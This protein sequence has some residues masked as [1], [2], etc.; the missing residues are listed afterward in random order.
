MHR[1]SDPRVAGSA[2]KNLQMFRELCGEKA[3]RNVV[4]VTNMWGGVDP[5]T[6]DQREQDLSENFL[7]HM[8]DQG[9]TMMR[10]DGSMQSAHNIILEVLRHRPRLLRIQRE[11]VREH[12]ELTET[13]ACYELDNQLREER[14]RFEQDL[15]GI[16][17]DIDRA[18]QDNDEG[19]QMELEQH[20]QRVEVKL[21]AM[22][23]ERDHLKR[24]YSLEVKRAK[25]A[26]LS[27]LEQ[28][29]RLQDNA[30]QLAERSNLPSEPAHVDN[31]DPPLPVPH[32]PRGGS[33]RHKE[34]PPSH[35]RPEGHQQQ[36][37]GHDSTTAEST[38]RGIPTRSASVT[39]STQGTHRSTHRRAASVN[40]SVTS[41]GPTDPR[42]MDFVGKAF[43]QP[44]HEHESAH[45]SSIH[46]HEPQ[47]MAPNSEQIGSWLVA[48][49]N[50]SYFLAPPTDGVPPRV[51]EKQFSM[52][53]RKSGYS[54]P[55]ADGD[56][57]RRSMSPVTSK[58]LKDQIRSITQELNETRQLLDTSHHRVADLEQA[59]DKLARGLIPEDG[60]LH[61]LLQV[62]FMNSVKGCTSSNWSRRL[63]WN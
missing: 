51:P 47:Q 62:S 41:R 31:E 27:F 57:I 52:T 23:S 50:C 53:S 24:N 36:G 5:Q 26:G 8:L 42:V 61:V 16:K 2:M 29:R 54:M 30:Q 22:R 7:K 43:P 20:K 34:R 14:D 19:V 40:P 10:H 35:D 49:L 44:V 25:Q 1:I 37:S 38:T 12:Q 4:F 58:I 18:L 59:V 45:M 21:Q 3:L 6:G 48:I 9:A 17:G 11:L 32:R 39:Y 13:T 63:L 28:S 60:S 46:S 15:L 56:I 55:G 33:R